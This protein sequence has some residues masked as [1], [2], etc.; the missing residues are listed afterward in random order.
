MASRKTSSVIWLIDETTGSVYVCWVYLHYW[1]FSG[2]VHLHRR[3]YISPVTDKCGQSL[4]DVCI[5]KCRIYSLSVMCHSRI[6][7]ERGIGFFYI[8]TYYKHS[9]Q[10]TSIFFSIIP[11]FQSGEERW[12]VSWAR[13]WTGHFIMHTGHNT[14]TAVSLKVP[15]GWHYTVTPS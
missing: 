2:L 11:C 5:N 7:E 14:A 3:W 12:S 4:S 15:T 13:S 1:V 9:I 6:D 8:H 10:Y